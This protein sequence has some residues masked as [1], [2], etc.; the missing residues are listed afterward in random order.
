MVY[1]VTF[2]PAL[3]YTLKL[4]GL[5]ADSIQRST[6]ETFYA[7]GKGIN[8]S[9]ILTQLEIPNIALGF[10]AGFTGMEIERLVY[11]LGIIPDFIH[12][13]SGNS[14]INV[15][16]RSADGTETDI[17]ARGCDLD[18]KALNEFYNKLDR[19]ETG[20]YLVLSGSIPNS[21]PSDIYEQILHSLSGKK[22][23]C[24]VDATGELLLNTLKYNPF[25]IK[26]NKEELGE[27]F[28]ETVKTGDD[29][30]RFAKALQD[31]GARNVLVSMGSEGGILLTEYGQ[32]IQ[33]SAI[34]GRAV[35]T[36]GAGD[37]MLAGFLA[38]WIKYEDY[39]KALNL[40]TASG[41]ATAFCEGIAA[42]DEILRL[43][44]TL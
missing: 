33:A 29:V 35:N 44:N 20:D 15:K 30:F 27:L 12:L 7:G 17:N 31:K 40:G 5:T 39:Q 9:N 24:L 2:N 42:K 34:H 1:T 26:P 28:G 3:D 36:V 4:E 43:Y 37:S 19:L 8:V 11:G 10:I 6:R 14:R 18:E 21:L 41:A 38:G 16:I 32:S 13:A 25:L 22:I 23:E